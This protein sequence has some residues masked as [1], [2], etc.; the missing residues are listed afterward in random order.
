MN[1]A[2]LGTQA[3][4]PYL[5]KLKPLLQGHSCFLPS[6]PLQFLALIV[7][8]C[9]KR[10]I[11]AVIT[12][13]PVILQK[14]V[15][16]ENLSPEKIVPKIN[17]YAGSIFLHEGIEFLILDP[18]SHL[19]S[20]PYGSFL[21]RRF[22][23]K[24]I[25]R[26]SWMEPLEFK[27][28]MFEES[29]AA[30]LYA[31][32]ETAQLISCDIETKR[33]HRSIECVGYTLV[34]WDSAGSNARTTSFVIPL[35]S[36]FF[37]SWVRKLNDLP[38][39]KI[40]QNGK[41]DNLYF[42]RYNSPVRN[43]VW[44]TAHFMHSWY[45]E[46]PKDLGFLNAFFLRRVV[47]W[48][49]LAET[50][51]AQE[52]FR[53][54][55]LDSWA[56]ANVLLSQIH[57]APAWAKHNYFLEFPLVFPSLL[58]E[59]T[60]LRR[61]PDRHL[62]ARREVDASIAR[63][64]SFLRRVLSAPNFNPGSYQQV[65]K[66]LQLLTGKAHEESDE[67]Y[68]KK[69]S[70]LHPFNDLILGKILSYRGLVK[71][72]GTYLRTDED[73]DKKGEGGAKEFKGQILYS[74]NPH[75]TETGRNACRESALWCG[76]QVQNIPAGPVVKSTIRSPEG[77]FLG[78]CDLEQ[79]ESRD[80]AFISGDPTLIHAVSSGQDF[81]SFNASA[82]FGVPYEQIYSD[83]LKK[84]I[85][86][87]LRTLAKP[88]NHGANYNMGPGVMADSVGL[89][90]VWEIKARLSLPFNNPLEVTEA[91]LTKFHLTYK[92]LRG[93]IKFKSPKVAQF[94]KLPNP[95][96][97]FFAPDTWYAKV[98]MEI[99]TSGLLV[100]RA[101]HHIPFNEKKW[102][103]VEEYIE[104]GD[105]TRKCFG[106]P[107]NNKSDLNAY[108]AHP[109]QS[110]NA[111]TLNEAF[112]QVFYDVALPHANDFR[113][114]AQIHDS[115]L[116]SYREGRDDLPLMVKDRMEI[117]VSVRA[118]DGVIRKFTVPAALKLGVGGK[119]A[120]YWSETE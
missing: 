79:A 84:A 10:D 26:E 112:M 57:E 37:L 71:L 59:G 73:M 64:L 106:D 88:I 15:D 54:C 76:F 86:K 77:F 53:Y 27:W 99:V 69:I 19:W 120:I 50:A 102:S 55:A 33:L 68:L 83:E 13:D 70:F 91:A 95:N 105:W 66:L 6:Q 48:K 61:D 22:I 62:Q 9:K 5:P 45:A 96:Y 42:L 56:T 30:Q 49:D 117:P 87:D 72:K 14:L 36:V 28:C 35:T 23:S 21:S 93:I 38:A 8:Y 78:E 7:A 17:D 110:L 44:D 67:V 24:L 85:R 58:A 94:F 25:S 119:K 12:T 16:K 82:F 3:D 75:G 101:Y 41:Y 60:G 40:F 115:I 116:F 108:V 103:K 39:A 32:A 11:Q 18:L 109:P 113:L 34:H 63:D 43:W 2:F 51:D 104:N 92:T 74:L 20:V 81:H 31:L 80:T 118:V 4:A 65:R 107:E 52:Y 98:T 89:K 100:S 111:R 47:Y 1:L 29:N 97:R 114:H 90:M 46:L